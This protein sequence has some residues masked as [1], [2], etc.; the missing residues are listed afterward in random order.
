M[1]KSGVI[2]LFGLL[3]LL[4]GCGAEQ[5]NGDQQ[6]LEDMTERFDWQGH[7]GARGLRPEN[8]IPAFLKALEFPVTTL[9]LDVVISRDSQVVVSHEPWMSHHICQTLEGKPVTRE[10]EDSLLL[11]KLPYQVIQR[12]DCGGRG[13]EAFPEQE[14]VSVAKPTLEAVVEAVQAYC[15]SNDR[16]LPDFNIEIKSKPEW[17]GVKTPEPAAFARLVLGEVRELGIADRSC[18]QSFDVRSLQ[19]VHRQA[20]EITTALLVANPGGIDSN[21]EELGYVPEIYSPYYKLVSANVVDTVHDRGMRII[22][23]TVNEVEEMEALIEMGVDGIIT[24]YPNR[25]EEVSVEE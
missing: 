20:P 17:D 13:N 15:R 22:P 4:Y 16:E 18:I 14:A 21:L 1:K 23:W 9:E 2:L 8:T 3:S 10:Q 19:A 6:S 7:R 25:V 12:Y 5:S 11:F 24:D